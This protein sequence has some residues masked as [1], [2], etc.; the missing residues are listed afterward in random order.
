[1]HDMLRP[2][3]ITHGRTFEDKCLLH[4]EGVQRL[5]FGGKTTRCI[6]QMPILQDART[7]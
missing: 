1:M 7:A 4:E 5:P 3:R 2:H 6:W